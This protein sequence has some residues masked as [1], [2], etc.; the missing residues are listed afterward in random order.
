M[1][2]KYEDGGAEVT[3]KD[4][5]ACIDNVAIAEMQKSAIFKIEVAIL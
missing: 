3:Q 4:R 2:A 5:K 1:N